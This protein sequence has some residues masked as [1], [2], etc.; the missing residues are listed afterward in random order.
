MRASPP[1]PSSR[2]LAPPLV[3]SSAKLLLAF[4]LWASIGGCDGLVTTTTRGTRPSMHG[5]PVRLGLRPLR[6]R[7]GAV[8]KRVTISTRATQKDV[9]EMA[10]PQKLLSTVKQ[11]SEKMNEF[12]TN[13][14]AWTP[15]EKDAWRAEYSN[16]VDTVAIPALSFAS[17][18]LIV[19]TAFFVAILTLLNKSGRGFEDV[20]SLI[21]GIP[22]FGENISRA[23]AKNLDSGVGNG[24]LA[25]VLVD[26]L[27]PLVVAAAAIITPLLSP[28][29]AEKLENIRNTL[30]Q[31]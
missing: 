2:P 10:D 20:T 26:L 22:L 8:E 17:A 4:G 9:S 18:N 21:E 3:P 24:I 16:L 12:S 7:T 30:E 25:L 31:R 15:A 1:S 13:S 19:S 6:G 27:A 29:Y 28:W 14:Q 11:L 5:D 23:L